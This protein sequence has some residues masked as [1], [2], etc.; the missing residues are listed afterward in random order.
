MIYMREGNKT[1]T[2]NPSSSHSYSHTIDSS[3]ST[4]KSLL[5]VRG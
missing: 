3:P 1:F 5:K 2:L 4:P